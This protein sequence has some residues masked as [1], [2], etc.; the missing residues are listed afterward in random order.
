M[1]LQVNVLLSKHGFNV[2]VIAYVKNEGGNISTMIYALIFVVSYE[3]L[4][5]FTPFIWTCWGHA[6]FKNCQYATND[7]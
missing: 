3:N 5:L 4:D 7:S 1:V 2:C 6:M